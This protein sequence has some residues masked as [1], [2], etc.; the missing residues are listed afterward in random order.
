MRS[1]DSFAAFR[2]ILGLCLFLAAAC[3]QAP[4]APL[5]V[6][7][8]TVPPAL[9][10]TPTPG[11]TELPQLA[12]VRV[13][14][15]SFT[16]DGKPF[17]FV[18]ANAIYFGFYQDYGYSIE[19][20]I[21][22]A[23]ENGIGVIRVYLGFGE[24]TW[25][26]K[27]FEEYDKVLDIAARNGVY[28]IAT[29]TD[30]CCMGGSWSQTTDAYFSKVPYCNL[31]STTDLA[32]FEDYAKG[33][34]MRKNTVNGKMYRDDTTILAWDL[35]NEQALQ[36]FSDS[37]LHAWLDAATKYIKSVDPNHLV[38]LGVDGSRDVYNKP[39]PHYDALNVPNLDFF[40]F[41]YNLPN[42]YAVASNLD[43]IRYRTEMLFSMKKPV[44]LEE[45]GVG[46]ERAL[47]QA[48]NRNML[49]NWVQSYKDQMD[50]AF[51]S[52]ASGVM[53]WGWGVP[54]TKT[55]PLWWK[56]EDHDV[57]ETEFTRLIKDYQIPAAAFTPTSA[58]M[59]STPEP[60]VPAPQPAYV[61][62]FCTLIGKPKT[63][64][65][66]V[67]APVTLLW[68]WDAKTEA[69][70]EDFV[71]NNVTTV[72]L[73][74]NVITSMEQYPTRKNSAGLYEVIWSAEVGILSPGQHLIL[75]D[76]RW[77]KMIDDGT[78]TYGPGGQVETQH[79]ECDVLVK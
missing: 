21:R 62:A 3:A 73:D 13:D 11:P 9:L 63:T 39:G 40:S 61:T 24:N 28:V 32:S 49:D 78:K 17:R 5:V 76:V 22:S 27:P 42:Y 44:I 69:Q 37:D 12:P 52:G 16:V 26:G 71:Q 45:F 66:A 68:G 64:T 51:S 10:A 75:Y 8:A 38:T 6:T 58:Q 48:V 1:S 55:V 54:E 79:V 46:S 35:A 74:G 33:I 72:T 47:P 19:Q 50:T 7:S 4:V 36:L 25:G 30:C 2:G 57:T 43:S 20:A 14:G 15:L 77:K 23:K 41:H 65:V 59:V 29:L 31:T 60:T 56:L 18:G 67:G 70:V 34:V 53:F